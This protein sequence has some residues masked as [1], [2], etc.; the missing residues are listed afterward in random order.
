MP[1][2]T[3]E[4]LRSGV[5][6]GNAISA[7]QKADP[8]VRLLIPEADVAEPQIS[9]VIPALDEERTIAEFVEWCKEGLAAVGAPGEILIV[10]S[11]SDKTNEIALGHGARVLSTPKRGLGRAYIDSMPY[12]RGQYVIV[13]DADCTY[14]FRQIAPFVEKLREG[15]EFVMGSRFRGTIEP[16]AM[17]AHHRYFGTPVTNWILNSYFPLTSPTSTAA[18]AD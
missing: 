10:S 7:T 3:I 16:K 17:P 4:R 2:E 8:E 11:S 13:G 6:V 5:S 1:T 15:Y 12:I 9:I 18:C 14:D